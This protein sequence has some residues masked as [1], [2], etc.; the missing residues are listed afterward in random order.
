LD[1][2]GR[3]DRRLREFIPNGTD[4]SPWLN[5][6]GKV[7]LGQHERSE[8]ILNDLCE[9]IEVLPILRTGNQLL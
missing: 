9:K 3:F 1:A 2:K 5:L 7:R 8:A 4:T 6:L